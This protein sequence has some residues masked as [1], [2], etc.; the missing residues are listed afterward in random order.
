M[1][2]NFS[3]TSLWLIINKR[4]WIILLASAHFV[5]LFILQAWEEAHNATGVF[6][7]IIK[8]FDCV[9]Y[10]S[11]IW[12]LTY[13]DVRG[14]ALELVKFYLTQRKQKVAI[15]G[16]VSAGSVVGMGVPQGSILAPFL[17]FVYINDLTYT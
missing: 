7:D 6:C 2:Y 11:L 4:Q 8:A 16:M 15:N 12:K 14:L 17:Y 5:Y 1:D 9:D 10:D 3:E 13:Y